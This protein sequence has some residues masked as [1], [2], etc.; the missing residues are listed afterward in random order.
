MDEVL[1]YNRKTL[2]DVF[3]TE[4]DEKTEDVQNKI[5]FLHDQL[6]RN[7]NPTIL[8][9]EVDKIRDRGCHLKQQMD[10]LVS[11]FEAKYHELKATR[12]KHIRT[13]EKEYSTY[14]LK[15]KAE[16]VRC[17]QVCNSD[18]L[19]EVKGII[20]SLDELLNHTNLP[21]IELSEDFFEPVQTATTELKDFFGK[22]CSRD[23]P[24]PDSDSITDK[25][26]QPDV[27]M[28]DNSDIASLLDSE[29]GTTPKSVSVHGDINSEKSFVQSEASAKSDHGDSEEV[30]DGVEEVITDSGN[31]DEIIANAT[32]S[33]KEDQDISPQSGAVQ[34]DNTSDKASIQSEVISTHDET[35]SGLEIAKLEEQNDASTVKLVPSSDDV[36][37]E[38]SAKH[39]SEKDNE[40]VAGSE[41]SIADDFVEEDLDVTDT[42]QV[43]EREEDGR[44][45]Q[46][47]E[48]ELASEKS[49]YSYASSYEDAASSKSSSVLKLKD[50]EE[51]VS[52]AK[53]GNVKDKE[54]RSSLIGD[55][56]SKD[57]V[58]G[59]ES[60]VID[61]EIRSDHEDSLSSETI[62][63]PVKEAPIPIVVS[64]SHGQNYFDDKPQSVSSLKQTS[65]SDVPE[66]VDRKAKD[67]GLSKALSQ[68]VPAIQVMKD[69]GI[70]ATQEFVE[71]RG[72]SDN[73]A[74]EEYS[75]VN[76]ITHV[77]DTEA[78]KQKVEVVHVEPQIITTENRDGSY[79]REGLHKNSTDVDSEEG[80]CSP[81]PSQPAHTDSH[82]IL[83]VLH[84]FKVKGGDE[85]ISICP[86]SAGE[87]AWIARQKGKHVFRAIKMVSRSG[88]VVQT[89]G[90]PRAVVDI[91]VDRSDGILVTCTDSVVRQMLAVDKSVVKFETD[92]DLTSLCQLS[93][94]NIVVCHYLTS[95][96]VLLDSTG[97]VLGCLDGK[98]RDRA[99]VGNPW[100]VRVNENNDDVVI[101]NRQGPSSIAVVDKDLNIRF[102]FDGTNTYTA[103]NIPDISSSASPREMTTSVSTT[104]GS[105]CD[106]RFIPVDACFDSSNNIIIAEYNRKAVLVLD[107]EGRL[108]GT[109]YNE[110]TRPTSLAV[111]S[112]G[113]L[114]VGYTNGKVDIIRHLSEKIN[115]LK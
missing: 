37:P 24:V 58:Q 74:S 107:A 105:N 98:G 50:A 88:K 46:D 61:K 31:K 73:G 78:M 35:A 21:S 14:L 40:S 97:D 54:E 36:E 13:I 28:G 68:S 19:Q 101:I 7:E 11:E 4:V 5:S 114:W 103:A 15:L 41:K 102:L 45:M 112:Q 62:D 104:S 65:R 108:L 43:L 93:S 63:K 94:G 22:M 8:Q 83:D 106:N 115:C 76:V 84:T 59:S 10:A 33:N 64:T 38:S 17:G 55:A 16:S 44:V 99:T 9:Q 77:K 80:R 34:D 20:K 79:E 111:D 67:N 32:S 91:S 23:I 87:C 53:E 27:D 85:V 18:N 6:M 12:T 72:K 110:C 56:D 1:E 66:D 75:N 51:I 82:D 60:S 70:E 49:R 100:K 52:L 71:T 95:K 96:V 47:T 30:D 86:L 113:N 29:H 90:F 25:A 109:L 81:I 2:T 42:S 48:D 69:T 26:P 92:E 89:S 57:D 39:S 3:M